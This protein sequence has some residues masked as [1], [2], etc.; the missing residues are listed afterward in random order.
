MSWVAVKAT[1][2]RPGVRARG[3]FGPGSYVGRGL[4]Q[5]CRAWVSS[6]RGED[7]QGTLTHHL[8]GRL[9]PLG[10]VVR[11]RNVLGVAFCQH[12]RLEGEDRAA[13]VRAAFTGVGS[14]RPWQ[15][16]H[17]RWKRAPR[18]PLRGVGLSREGPLQVRV[19][20]GCG[21]RA[22]LSWFGG[23]IRLGQVQ[24]LCD[25]PVAVTFLS[26]GLLEL[27]VLGSWGSVMPA[28][29]PVV[30]HGMPPGRLDPE[31]AMAGSWGCHSP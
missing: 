4:G 28:D 31:V 2:D 10:S 27:P 17:T 7:V 23:W 8:G 19:G 9:E 16:G 15:D 3:D 25:P 30:R 18:E 20:H 14:M 22:L 29:L 5:K 21:N 11:A 12:D 13:G 24:R 26:E 1:S 6:W